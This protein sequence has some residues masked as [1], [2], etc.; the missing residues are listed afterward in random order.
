MEVEMD[1]DETIT[2]KVEEESDEGEPYVD[3]DKEDADNSDSDYCVN[4]DDYD[5]DDSRDDS[6]S[7]SSNDKGHVDI[8]SDEDDASDDEVPSSVQSDKVTQ[9]RNWKKYLGQFRQLFFFF[10]CQKRNFRI[11][12]RKSLSQ[13]AKENQPILAGLDDMYNDDCNGEDKIRSKVYHCT[14]KSKVQCTMY[15]LMSYTLSL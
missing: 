3:S 15:F 1:V 8:A 10:P 13:I 4:E 2:N 7:H 14:S 6:A 12:H 5:E 11:S 9:K